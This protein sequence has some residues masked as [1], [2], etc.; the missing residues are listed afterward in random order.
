MENRTKSRGWPSKS[1]F[2]AGQNDQMDSK[3]DS[4]IALAI[5]I[6]KQRTSRRLG[7]ARGQGGSTEDR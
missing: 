5:G 1:G 4:D 3:Q 2:D 7:V 6:N